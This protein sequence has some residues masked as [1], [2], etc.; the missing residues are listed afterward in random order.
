M[1]PRRF[2]AI[3]A[4]LTGVYG[5]SAATTLI[6]GNERVLLLRDSL[7]TGVLALVLLLSC[8]LRRPLVFHAAKRVGSPAA[9]ADGD[10]RWATEPGVR[11]PS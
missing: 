11:P 3:A 10:V 6:T 8:A 9:G 1:R 7:A 4:L 2:D 5:L